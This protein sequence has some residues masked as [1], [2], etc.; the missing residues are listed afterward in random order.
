[1]ECVNVAQVNEMDEAGVGSVGL[2]RRKRVKISELS[3]DKAGVCDRF[4]RRLAISRQPNSR[5]R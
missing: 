2:S 3:G 5:M 4:T 1:M